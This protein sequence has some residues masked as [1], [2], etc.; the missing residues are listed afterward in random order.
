MDFTEKYMSINE[1]AKYQVYWTTYEGEK[2]ED[3]TEANQ[4][5]DA[6]NNICKKHG[7]NEKSTR[8]CP[9]VMDD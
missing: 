6:V 9:I 3:I 2:G 5:W 1:M 8:F 4:P 7:L